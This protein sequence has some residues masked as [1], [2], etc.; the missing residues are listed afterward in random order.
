M[1]QALV[2]ALPNFFI[3]FVVECDV[4]GSSI[5]A[6]LLQDNM[7]SLFFRKA[8]KGCELGLSTFEKEMMALVSTFQKWRPYLL[9]SPSYRPTESQISHQSNHLH[10]DSIVVVSKID[11]V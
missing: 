2:L 8:I 3:S 10:Y 4:S 9:S 11:V 5:E 7:Q 6:I 1:T